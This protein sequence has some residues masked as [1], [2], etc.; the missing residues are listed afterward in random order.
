MRKSF[1]TK[2]Y[3][4]EP[5]YGTVN[6]KEQRSFMCSK[7]LEIEDVMNVSTQKILWKESE[8]NTQGIKS[9][10]IQM[11]FN[12]TLIKSSNHNIS[13][14]SSDNSEFPIWEI[15]INIKTI[16]TEY[17]FAQ[18]KA[19]NIFS[20]IKNENTYYENVNKSI[21]Q[22]IRD[23]IY[24]RIKFYN[25]EVFIKPKY[26]GFDTDR[27]EAIIREE[28]VFTED[29]YAEENKIKE[30]QISTSPLFDTA[31]VRYRQQESNFDTSFDYY[32]NVIWKKA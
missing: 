12:P 20:G 29:V 17:L 31:T 15:N 24:P 7:I 1:M 18:L 30:F 25:I 14:N 26:I 10:I 16:I 2:E 22:Y 28:P 13:N 23:N 6:M 9:D 21:F 5:I 4:I 11:T 32:F 3:S 19:S 27:Q 8:D